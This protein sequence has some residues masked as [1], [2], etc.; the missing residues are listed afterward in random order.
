MYSRNNLKSR[1]FSLLFLS[2]LSIIFVACS[3]ETSAL[4]HINYENP[5]YVKEINIEGLNESKGF[6]FIFEIGTNDRKLLES[7]GNESL[8][9]EFLSEE[10]A[11]ILAEAEIDSQNNIDEQIP[12]FHNEDEWNGSSFAK[13]TLKEIHAPYLLTEMPPY[14][15]L[16][17]PQINELIKELKA[18]TVLDFEENVEISIPSQSFQKARNYVQMWSRNK[19]VLLNGDCGTKFTKTT[20]YWAETGQGYNSNNVLNSTWFK[21]SKKI[22]VCCSS[23][24]NKAN[25]PWIRRVTVRYD[26]LAGFCAW[27]SS[28]YGPTPATY[29]TL[30][31]NNSC[32]GYYPKGCF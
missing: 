19:R 3:K 7:F 8:S 32:N 25:N 27:H 20:N 4:E 9:M 16:I 28:C 17:S 12:E 15:L 22:A 1:I 2:F 30:A 26:V 29:C 21:C 23:I 31:A 14:E 5:S 6:E 11:Q 24:L 13:I 18:T 10:K